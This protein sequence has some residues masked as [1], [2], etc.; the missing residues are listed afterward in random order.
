MVKSEQ[1]KQI[2]SYIAERVKIARTDIGL[3]RSDLSARLNLGYRALYD[4]EQNLNMFR[5]VELAIIAQATG[6]PIEWFYPSNE[7]KE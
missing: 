4:K 3:S 6:K 7:D 1:M 5:A 2:N